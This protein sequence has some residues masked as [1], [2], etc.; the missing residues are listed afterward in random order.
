MTIVLDTNVLVS[1]LIVADHPPGRIVDLIRAGEVRLALDDRVAAEY[2]EVLARPYIRRYFTVREKERVLAFILSDSVQCVC[3]GRIEGLPDK[4][5]A[6]FAETAL[7]AQAPLIT[8]NL[9]HF[10]SGAC[11]EI[12]VMTPAQFLEE[13]HRRRE[14]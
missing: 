3:T 13:L 7:A 12:V 14:R 11:R 10:P 4:K 6:P 8:G 1:G 5:D 2:E 9:K